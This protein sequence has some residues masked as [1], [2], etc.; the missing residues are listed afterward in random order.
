MRVIC[1]VILQEIQKP[2]NNFKAQ[3]KNEDGLLMKFLRPIAAFYSSNNESTNV[4][5]AAQETLA[6]FC[7]AQ[8]RSFF[9]E[10]LFECLSKEQYDAFCDRLEMQ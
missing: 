6:V 10:A 5:I 3:S 4:R 1:M 2:V 7:L 8:E 9:L